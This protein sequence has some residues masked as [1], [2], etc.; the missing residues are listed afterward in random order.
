MTNIIKCKTCEEEFYLSR[1]KDG[2]SKHSYDKHLR[3]CQKAFKREQD[4]ALVAKEKA[5]EKL[6]ELEADNTER[7]FACGEWRT[8]VI[9]GC[10]RL[11]CNVFI[12]NTRAPL[13]KERSE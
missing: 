10:P 13:A 6:L 1:Y 4:E 11:D 5:E 3:S 7:C 12:T 9:D 2:V 8:G